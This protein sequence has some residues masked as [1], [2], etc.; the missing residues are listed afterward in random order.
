MVP[1]PA[2]PVIHP[3]AALPL[4]LVRRQSIQFSSPLPLA[5]GGQGGGNSAAQTRYKPGRYPTV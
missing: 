2:R 1:S 4:G 3:G 5:G